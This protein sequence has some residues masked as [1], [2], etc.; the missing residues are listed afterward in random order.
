MH[1][2]KGSGIWRTLSKVRRR[3]GNFFD[4]FW[5]LGDDPGA[6]GSPDTG[7][8]VKRL[9]NV[10]QRMSKWKLRGCSGGPLG[11]TWDAF[12]HT[13]GHLRALMASL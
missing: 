13:L 10:T 5:L 4:E 2:L 12:G 3:F 1:D 8:E 6:T 9:E 11:V 7:E